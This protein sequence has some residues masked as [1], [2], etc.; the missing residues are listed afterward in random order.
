MEEAY[1][2]LDPS[3]NVIFII[4]HP[5]KISDFGL[6]EK[7]KSHAKALASC[8]GRINSRF[9][10]AYPEKKRDHSLRR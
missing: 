8:M 9:H 7:N 4:D 1:S 2:L 10:P 5:K 6:R 3:F